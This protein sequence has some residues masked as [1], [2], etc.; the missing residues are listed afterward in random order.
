MRREREF[1]HAQEMA[2]AVRQRMERGGEHE[3]SELGDTGLETGDRAGNGM[4]E[5]AGWDTDRMELEERELRATGTGG[6]GDGKEDE[7]AAW[8][9]LRT[10]EQG[11]SGRLEVERWEEEMMDEMVD[12]EGVGFGGDWG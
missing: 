11:C 4:G 12:R 5:L 6:D 7:L 9:E 8:G 10:D 1:V 3:G 2:R